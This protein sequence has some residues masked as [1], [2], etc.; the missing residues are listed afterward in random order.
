MKAT[1][2]QYVQDKE[3]IKLELKLNGRL[4]RTYSGDGRGLLDSFMDGM[5]YITGHAYMIDE[6]TVEVVKNDDIESEE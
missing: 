4:V 2:V 5:E 6:V 3:F 1:I